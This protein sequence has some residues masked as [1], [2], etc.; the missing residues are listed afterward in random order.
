MKERAWP[1][2]YIQIDYVSTTRLEQLPLFPT[3]LGRGFRSWRGVGRRVRAGHS[4]HARVFG[5]F[6]GLLEL[7]VDMNRLTLWG[8]AA[9]GLVALCVTLRNHGLTT[10]VHHRSTPRLAFSSSLATERGEAARGCGK[11]GSALRTACVRRR[12]STQKRERTGTGTPHKRAAECIVSK[13]TAP[14]HRRKGVLGKGT[15]GSLGGRFRFHLVEVTRKH[16]VEQFERVKCTTSETLGAVSPLLRSAS[17]VKAAFPNE[18][19]PVGGRRCIQIKRVR[20]HTAIEQWVL[21][22]VVFPASS[23]VSQHLVRLSNHFEL[24]CRLLFFIGRSAIRVRS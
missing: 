13:Y 6:E 7:S 15:A 4:F 23:L 11:R 9:H 19:M 1:A 10:A 24:R 21:K 8:N 18:R 16:G 22:S 14:A 20:W 17:R 3:R 2:W 5:C 12:K